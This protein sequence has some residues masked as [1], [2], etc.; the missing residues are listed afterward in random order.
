M[1]R[2]NTLSLFR[3][4]IL[5]A[6]GYTPGEQPS[7]PDV[8]KLN[9]NENPY[10]PSPRVTELLRAFD[11]ATLRKYPEPTSRALREAIAARL[12][13]DAGNVLVGNGSD[14][15]I[16]LLINAVCEP[17]D[18]IAY[19][20]P[21]YTYYKSSADLFG[22]RTIEIPFTEDFRLSAK[23][24]ENS[25]PAKLIFL[26]RPNSPSGTNVPLYEIEKICASNEAIV[27]VDEAYVD[28][29]EDSALS[30]LFVHSNLVILRTFSKGYSLAGIRVGY[31]LAEKEIIAEMNKLRDSYNVN[32]LSQMIAL[33]AFEDEPYHSECISKVTKE[34][35]RLSSELKKMGFRL[36]DSQA[37][38][39]LAA[40]DGVAGGAF[41]NALKTNEVFIRYFAHIPEYIRI[42]IG[43]PKQNDALI[44]GIAEIIAPK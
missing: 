27:I 8:I 35:S 44:E 14:E 25:S 31:M 26:C 21:T 42:T 20:F 18:S 6:A 15:L 30:L 4:S 29:S 23:F 13:L 37:N 3:K 9:T 12:D 32:S 43:T 19:P 41:Y 2:T 24:A 10:P 28:F 17:G 33:A 38:F 7:S 34:R 5:G 1:T 39:I 36:F 16:K 40:H 22:V 11:P